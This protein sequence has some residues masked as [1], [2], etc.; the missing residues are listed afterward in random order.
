MILSILRSIFDWSEVWALLIPL[1]FVIRCKPKANWQKPVKWYLITALLLNVSLDFVWYVNKYRLFDSYPG[2]RWNNNIFYNLNSV[3]RLFFFAWFFNS[4][5]QRFVHRIKAIIPYI[6]L[7]FLLVNFIFFENFFPFGLKEL[8]SSRLLATESAFLI[9]Y[10]LQYYIYL[11]VEEKTT[12]IALQPGFWIVTGL[13]IYV[14]ASFFIFLF[15]DYLNDANSKFAVSI[16][17][18]HN[19]AFIILG[20]SIAMQFLQECRKVSHE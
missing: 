11:I 20:I 13:S 16:W 18:V 17:D 14:A 15:F 3:A 6:F 2:H 5:H 10:C 9:F 4:L 12:K 19:I 8:F 1:I 7:L